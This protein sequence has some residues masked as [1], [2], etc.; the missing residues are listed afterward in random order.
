LA[1]RVHEMHVEKAGREGQ[2]IVDVHV[3][4]DLQPAE[5]RSSQFYRV[6][7]VVEYRVDDV[8]VRAAVA[9]VRPDAL[10][11]EWDGQSH[12]LSYRHVRAVFDLSRIERGPGEKLL[13][14]EKVKQDG[15]VF[16]KGSRQMITRVVGNT[17][18][19]ESG[20]QL[21][22]ND[23]R[24]RQGDCLTDYK[25]QG[26]KGAQV[27]GIE[28]NG[29]A[30]AMA[31]KEAFHVKG[32]R[33]VQNL[34]LHVENK[35]LYVE[36]IQRTNMK[37]SAL[38]LERQ[39]ISPVVVSPLAV[40]K[41]R[42]LM[43]VRS[44]GR[45]FLPRVSGQKRAERV[46]RQL[47]RFEA[48][49]PRP[50]EAVAEKVTPAVKEAVTEKLTPAVKESTRQTPGERLT[51]SVEEMAHKLRQKRREKIAQKQK[52]APRVRQNESEWLQPAPPSQRQ[53]PRISM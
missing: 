34:I 35:S 2:A 36:A 7:D 11:V 10:T 9:S 43:Q 48:L 45:E 17:I 53:G 46:R 40:N 8:V 39:P 50:V 23:G 13:L 15:R 47:A 37:F 16:E 3:K 22:V 26:I 29:S 51:P 49:R 5:L 1:E 32:T 52:A 28:D 14:Q 41:G 19:F 6:G 20:L 27:R 31:N 24:V 4:R 44:W 42:L 18:Q 30:M 12:Q 25:A 21:R 38:Q 33:H